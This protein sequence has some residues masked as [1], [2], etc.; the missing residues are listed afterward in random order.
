MR[1]VTFSIPEE[2]YAAIEAMLE[3]DEFQRVE[4]NPETR[5]PR[6]TKLYSSVEDFMAQRVIRDGL[7]QYGGMLPPVVALQQQIQTTQE[8]INE[9]LTPVV[10]A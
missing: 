9:L 5:E 3:R 4:I 2:V 7:K 10:I 6:R 8:R 1:Q